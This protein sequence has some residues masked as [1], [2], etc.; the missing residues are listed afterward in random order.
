[1]RTITL[2]RSTRPDGGVDTSPS[3]PD[4][5]DYTTLYRLIA[6][7]GKVLTDGTNTCRCIDVNT[8]DGWAET[9]DSDD[10]VSI[11]ESIL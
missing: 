6:S 8:V 1:M 3:V 5:G 4:S 2:Y 9:Y 10:M 7:Q 11:I